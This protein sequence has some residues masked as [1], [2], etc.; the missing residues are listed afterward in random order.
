MAGSRDNE[1]SSGEEIYSPDEVEAVLKSLGIDIVDETGTDFLSLCPYHNNTYSP[2]F[3]TAKNAGV[4]V[5]FNPTCAVGKSLERLVMDL[6]KIDKYAAKRFIV[7]AK[8]K[9]GLTFEEKF[10]MLG[11]VET[12]QPTFPGIA[13]D[14]M[15]ERFLETDYAK[16]YMYSRGFIDDTL[17]EFKVGFTP[18]ATD[19]SDLIYREH[20]MVVVPAYNHRSEPV[21]IVGRSIVGKHF[22]N[23]G[24]LAGGKGFQKSKIIWNLNNARKHETI[25]LCESTFDGMRI[26]Q[27]GYPNVGALLGG[28]LSNTQIDLLNRHFSNI[29]IFTDNENE[30]NGNVIYPP[31]CRKCLSLGYTMCQGHRPGRDLGLSIVNA[32]PRL[33]IKWAVYDDIEIYARGVKDASDMTD[34]EIRQTLRNSISHFEYLDW[35]E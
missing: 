17:K 21:G 15:H 2:A 5:C 7:K 18:A 16:E 28:S 22:K 11:D 23:Y 27:A 25:I 14:K 4:S 26:H 29:I 9:S 34:D 3:A 8:G 19:K 10:A 13:I 31:S 12:D 35:I 30:K 20:D 1:W 6:K 33:N 24:P 32:L